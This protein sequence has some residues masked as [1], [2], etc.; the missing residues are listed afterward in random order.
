MVWR[1]ACIAHGD[2]CGECSGVILCT[3][4]GAKDFDPWE[5][6]LGSGLGLRSGRE[7]WRRGEKWRG[8]EHH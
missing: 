5:L 2:E 4:I 7:G 8:A 6:V 1:H 3:C